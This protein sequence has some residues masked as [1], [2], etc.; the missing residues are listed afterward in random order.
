MS[1][2]QIGDLFR[3]EGESK[4]ALLQWVGDY[5]ENESQIAQLV[6]VFYSQRTED[7]DF[8]TLVKNPELY[9]IYFPIK[10]SYRTKLIDRI[11]N[12][13]IPKDFSFANLMKS[14][15]VVR[16]QFLGWHIVDVN[17]LQR[18]L[19]KELSEVEKKLSP[20]GIWNKAYLIEHLEMNWKL[21]SWNFN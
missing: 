21:D 10:A 7:I 12:Y 17:T 9:L 11:G 1:K 4:Q 18:K 2:L 5:R 3:V 15:H 8:A 20:F 13:P 6:R 16:G 19:V 14:P